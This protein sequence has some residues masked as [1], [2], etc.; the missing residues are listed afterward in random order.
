MLMK[1]LAPSIDNLKAVI[2]VAVVSLIVATG[3]LSLAATAVDKIEYF[4]GGDPSYSGIGFISDGKTLYVG[5]CQ[6]FDL[7]SRTKL[8]GCRYPT[9]TRWATVSP[10]GTLILATSINSKT[11]SNRST[12]FQIDALTGRILSSK[13]GLHFVPPVAIH[14]SNRYW[15]AVRAGKA[16][17]ASET[18]VAIDR[19]WIILKDHVYGE[20]QRI[21]ALEFTGDGSK[22]LV[23]GGGPIDGAT[24]QT[25]T[26]K[27]AKQASDVTLEQGILQ[28]SPNGRLVAKMEGTKL[29]LMDITTSATITT[30]D[31][32]VSDGEPQVAFS[33]DGRWFAAKGHRMFGNQRHYVFALAALTEQ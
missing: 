10:D 21:F 30:I 33:W 27:M 14:P 31:L 29:V 1:F 17:S 18:V 23:N 22:L 20:T 2:L 15:A 12:S 32:D 5:G 8:N 4:D 24:L 16:T 26:W 19:N 6:V 25:A 28:R 11:K 7:V 13:P 3:S 9:N